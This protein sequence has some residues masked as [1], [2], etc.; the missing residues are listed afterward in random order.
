MDPEQRR[1][2]RMGRP[3]R[4]IEL[5]AGQYRTQKSGGALAESQEKI[6]TLSQQLIKAQENERNRIAGYLHDNVAQD[7][8]SL[9]IGLE[10]LFDRG[11]EDISGDKNKNR[12]IVENPAGIDYRRA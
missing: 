7:L 8:S 12:R 3:A 11:Q 5:S 2:R 10:T 6:R 1:H 9:K 4:H